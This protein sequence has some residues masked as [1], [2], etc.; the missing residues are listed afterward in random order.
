MDDDRVTKNNVKFLECFPFGFGQEEVYQNE[1]HRGGNQENEEELPS[2]VGKRCCGWR[3]ERDGS[4]VENKKAHGQAFGAICGGE[5]FSAVY[6][7]DKKN[8]GAEHPGSLTPSQFQIEQRVDRYLQELINKE[9][10]DCYRISGFVSSPEVICC[11]AALDSHAQYRSANSKYYIAVKVN[12]R[13]SRE[14]A[15][16]SDDLRSRGF[17]PILSTSKTMIIAAKDPV[18]TYMQY[19]R[20]G[21]LPSRPRAL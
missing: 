16:C 2:D 12:Y 7:D 11:E 10:Q 21:R 14:A 19:M 1:R 17:R 13:L 18:I 20:R 15:I 5:Y 3:Q 9:K 6:G 8:S 4:D